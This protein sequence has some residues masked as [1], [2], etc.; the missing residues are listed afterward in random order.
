MSKKAAPTTSRMASHPGVKK[1]QPGRLPVARS[2]AQDK[3]RPQGAKNVV[4]TWDEF[5]DD[6]SDLPDI[7]M[8]IVK[9]NRKIEA[10]KEDKD[11][12][13][14]TIQKMMESVDKTKSWSVRD[15]GTDWI[16]TYVAKGK[17]GKK[18][19]PE[20]LLKAGVTIVQLNKGYAETPA[21]DPYVQVKTKNDK[22]E[23]GESE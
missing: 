12:L 16:A 18:L 6:L 8:E 22:S 13:R 19:V 1:G 23:T 5:G 17:P 10:L 15:E 11:A 4:P 20:K 9:I 7:A 3:Y 2:T 21:K 14:L